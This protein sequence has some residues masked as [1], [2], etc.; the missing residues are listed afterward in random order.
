MSS[1]LWAEDRESVKMEPEELW[2]LACLEWGNLL[3]SFLE[4]GWNQ[5]PG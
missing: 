3:L 4:T 2:K 5:I 1:M